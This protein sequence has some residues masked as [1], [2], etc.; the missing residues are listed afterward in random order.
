MRFA[1]SVIDDKYLQ[2]GAAGVRDLGAPLGPESALPEGAA[3]REYQRGAIFSHPATGTF[4]THGDIWKRYQDL[5]TYKGLLGYPTTDE[6]PCPD[7]EG[8]FNH[9][10]GG[11]IYWT[12][13]TGAHEVTGAIRTRWEKLGWEKYLGYPISGPESR[14]GLTTGHFTG[15]HIADHPAGTMSWR[16][17]DGALLIV[18]PGADFT[19]AAQAFIEHKLLSGIATLVHE[20]MA[21]PVGSSPNQ[22]ARSIKQTIWQVVRDY[23][24][25]WVML[26]GDASRLPVIYRCT[27]NDVH[28]S[29]RWFT[30]ADFYYA[31]VFSRHQ[32]NGDPVLDSPPAPWEA[33]GGE[34]FNEHHWANDTSSFNPG[35]VDGVADVA[36]GRVPAHSPAQ[37]QQ[38][39]DKVIT[40]ELNPPRGN[41]GLTFVLDKDYD[42]LGLTNRVVDLAGQG[43]LGGRTE[44]I[45]FDWRPGESP[46]PP[47]T[48]AKPWAL[49]FAAADSAWLF[50]IGHGGR[51]GW[52]ISDALGA[53]DGARV[54]NLSNGSHLPVVFAAGCET[55]RMVGCPPTDGSYR[56]IDDQIHRYDATGGRGDGDRTRV[57]IFI[58]GASVGSVSSDPSGPARI[59]PL[60]P[61]P[62]DI[63]AGEATTVAAD[64][65]FNVAGGAIAYFGESAVAPNHWGSELGG[66]ILRAYSGRG[67]VLGDMYLAGQVSYWKD[68]KDSAADDMQGAPRIWLSYVHLFG[69]PS[70]RLW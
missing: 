13:R 23:G 31:N 48:T 7:G 39:L 59:T 64:W 49:Q 27:S 30:H 43:T 63:P 14:F 47:I 9:F 61:H 4:S 58:N 33:N 16:A 37:V 36:V 40:Y 10:T 38:Y 42:T 21:Q 55:G 65:L 17:G 28:W 3:W 26:L 5:G 6:S 50:Y 24:V 45:G 44:R 32:P 70:L 11:S 35:Q 53:I 12:G 41:R 25:R 52:E 2:L 15:G 66:R 1:M 62:F 60:L 57:E 19:A 18:S 54:G 56:A 29:T 8:R 22:Q 34:L 68:F 46:P 67:S 51:G 20:P 69:D